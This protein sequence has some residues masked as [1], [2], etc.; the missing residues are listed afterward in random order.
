M[1]TLPGPDQ[2]PDL[3]RGV[4]EM[5]PAHRAARIRRHDAAS[6]SPQRKLRPA[7][8][9][10]LHPLS[11]THHHTALR[12][13]DPA[14]LRRAPHNRTCGPRGCGCRYHGHQAVYHT[15]RYRK[16]KKSVR[17]PGAQEDQHRP[18]AESEPH[19]RHVH[20]GRVQPARTLGRHVR[21]RKPRKQPLQPLI[22]I[23][24]LG[25]RKNAYRTVHRP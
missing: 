8:R 14:P 13:A 22:Y 11:Q 19:L 18:P 25:A 3:R 12:T 24:G 5:V 7:D 20:R 23:R 16:Y 21:R 4:P 17:F 10:K 2:D 9:E 6:E 15:N 1:A